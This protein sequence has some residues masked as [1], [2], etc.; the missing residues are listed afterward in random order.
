MNLSGLWEKKLIRP[1]LALLKQGVTAP[2]IA[3]GIAFGITLGVFPVL[4]STTLL[5][6]LAALVFRLNQAAIQL[7]NYLVYPLQI[8]LLIPFFRAGDR[9]FQAESLP[10]SVAE[11]AAL[12]E[13]DVGGAVLLLWDTTLRAIAVWFIVGPVATALLYL[14]LKPAVQRLAFRTVTRKGA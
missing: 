8:L 9:L 10:L 2:K 14:L 4:G 3:L 1:I 11:V 12:V 6:A 5:C 7:V 13:T